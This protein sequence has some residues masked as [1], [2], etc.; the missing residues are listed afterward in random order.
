MYENALLIEHAGLIASLFFSFFAFFTR[1]H[2]F[3]ACLT[4]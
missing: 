1:R 4:L 2:S 3:G